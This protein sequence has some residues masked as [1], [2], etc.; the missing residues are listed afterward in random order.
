MNIQPTFYA[1][2]SNKPIREEMGYPDH[3]I[4]IKLEQAREYNEKKYCIYWNMN[5]FDF[6]KR[7]KEDIR[8]INCFYADL[9]VGTD[10]EMKKRIKMCL[11]PSSIIKTGS[12]Y[13]LYWWLKEKII[14]VNNPVEMADWFRDFNVKR[15]LP[16]LNSD[17]QAADACRLLRAPMYRYWKDGIG[18]RF[19][20]IVFETDNQYSL[21]ELERA[22]PEKKEP[23][24][25][26]TINHKKTFQDNDSFWTKANSLNA[27]DALNK[28]S[29]T[30]H[31]NGEIITIRPQGKVTRIYIGREPCNAW[32]DADG[33]IGSTAG[34]GPGIPN[35]L[36]YY[37]KDWKKVADTIKEVFGI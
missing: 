20:D 22:F 12:G 5:E 14:C 4:P 37:C 19:V 30:K 16:L 8:A 29:G 2:C 13:H 28:L 7:K 1:F 3:P 24:K 18:D 6:G 31:V 36:W 32:I 10:E 26:T 25:P 23:I 35:W 11:A 17:S 33:K 21:N 34:A 9:D 15:I 27:V